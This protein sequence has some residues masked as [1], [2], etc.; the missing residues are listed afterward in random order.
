MFSN[1]TP[2][3]IQKIEMTSFALEELSLR[4]IIFKNQTCLL[5]RFA[6]WGDGP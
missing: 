6:F 1:V 2:S 4:R 5:Q 3:I